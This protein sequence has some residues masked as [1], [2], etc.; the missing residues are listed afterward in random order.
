M[1]EQK[2]P[3]AYFAF[4]TNCV[5]GEVRENLLSA[6]LETLSIKDPYQNTPWRFN[7]FNIEELFKY[8][9]VITALW[10]LDSRNGAAGFQQPDL[11]IISSLDDL[12]S[13][14]S[15]QSLL[16]YDSN[17][18]KI[19]EESNK[20]NLNYIVNATYSGV[21]KNAA[22]SNQDLPVMRTLKNIALKMYDT[23]TA[24]KS[25]D[26]SNQLFAWTQNSKLKF[27]KDSKI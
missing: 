8:D 26:F 15:A 16:E 7:L 22:Q 2:I 3:S 13:Y 27:C 10:K 19:L 24:K 18:E 11:P 12:Y 9:S 20:K 14:L 17:M 6:S 25:N 4:Q 5:K 21:F 23:D 1:E